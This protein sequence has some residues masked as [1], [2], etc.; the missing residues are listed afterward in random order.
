MIEANK[1]RIFRR[2]KYVVRRCDIHLFDI[3]IENNVTNKLIILY[4]TVFY[5]HCT[6]SFI[7]I[8]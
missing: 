5:L 6:A 7:M 2:Y 3:G 4:V 1:N 8:W